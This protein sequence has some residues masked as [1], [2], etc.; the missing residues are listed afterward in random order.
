MEWDERGLLT[1]PSA[2]SAAP[3]AFISTEMGPAGPVM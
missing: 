2:I 1:S 3:M